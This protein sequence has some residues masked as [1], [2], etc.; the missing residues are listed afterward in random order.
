VSG[1][2]SNASAE[3]SGEDGD[4]DDDDDDE[5]D[6]D[7]DDE[8]ED[9]DEDASTGE[10]SEEEEDEDEP[11]RKPGP[12][13]GGK[14]KVKKEAK[15]KV[16]IDPK[17][18][19]KGGS[20]EDMLPEHLRGMTEEGMRRFLE[21]MKLNDLLNPGTGG[22][23][24]DVQLETL[25]VLRK[26]QKAQSGGGGTGFLDDASSDDEASTTLKG[27]EVR[28]FKN[29]SNLRKYIKEHGD[30]LEARYVDR[31]EDTLTEG[32]DRPWAWADAHRSIPWGACQTASRAW[33]GYSAILRI[34][35]RRR[36]PSKLE[37]WA[38]GQCVQMMKTME[39]HALDNGSWLTGWKLSGL[40]DPSKRRE[41]AGEE[42]EMS[43]IAAHTKAEK[44]LRDAVGKGRSA[45][46]GPAAP[47]APDGVS[48]RAARRQR[49]ATNQFEGKKKE[50]EEKRKKAALAAAAA[51]AAAAGGAAIPPG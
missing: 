37:K 32:E 42:T 14:K 35:R 13:P 17:K 26:I 7:D 3:P 51:K 31:W 49:S 29:L 46:A 18:K 23:S 33:V 10:S 40:V 24:G 48:K 8:E 20:S 30:V 19:P 12:K 21:M 34:L 25:K 15:K 44:S 4:D 1:P 38:R 45:A 11:S 22:T 41:Y 16:T 28:A 39:Q 43:L 6:D 36:K 47:G 27:A 9:G 2:K 5:D 50:D